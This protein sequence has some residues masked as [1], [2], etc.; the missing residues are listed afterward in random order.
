MSHGTS[1]PGSH[2]ASLCAAQAAKLDCVFISSLLQMRALSCRARARHWARQ[3]HTGLNP[4]H[5]QNVFHDPA[6]PCK[7]GA[8]AYRRACTLHACMH[9][10]CMHAC[11]HGNRSSIKPPSLPPSRLCIRPLQQ[12]PS[13]GSPGCQTHRQR[14]SAPSLKGV[15][16]CVRSAQGTRKQQ[17]AARRPA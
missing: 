5:Q 7:A 14:Q 1:N 15:P 11:V 12:A 3:A 2:T 10:S 17:G 9:A 13:T 16:E 6:A 4:P 8:T